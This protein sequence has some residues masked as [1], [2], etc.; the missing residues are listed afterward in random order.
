LS[1]LAER[2]SADEYC[3]LLARRH[4]ENFIV[5]SRFVP[6]RVSLDLMRIYAYCRSTDDYGDESGDAALQRLHSWR[7]DV[8]DFFAGAMPVH[9]VLVALRETVARCRLPAQPFFDL[10]QANVQ[11][12]KVS[13]YES[14]PELHAYC[15]L[16]AAPVGRLVLRVFDIH[17]RRAEGLSDDVCIG[18]QLANHAQDV[19]RDADRGRCYLLQSDVRTGGT[20][21]AVKSLCDRARA[22]LH[23][24]RELEAMAPYPL[25]MQLALYRLGGL[26]IVGAIER[27]GCRTDITRPTVPKLTKAALLLRALLDGVLDHR[28]ATKLQEV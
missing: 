16:S 1:D 11:D 17:D 2:A 7:S 19:R 23:S 27:Q 26:A 3:R 4:Y 24:G 12:Q 15:M 13:R 18:L 6:E 8:S 5:A 22:L 9:P 14:W 21:H 25:K 28:H 10:I 20:A